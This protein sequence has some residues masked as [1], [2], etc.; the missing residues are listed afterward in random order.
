MNLAQLVHKQGPLPLDQTVRLIDRPVGPGAR[1]RARLVHRDLKPENMLI[2]PDG[3]LRITDFGLAL[4]LR[5]DARFGGATSRSGTPQF[6]SPEQLLGERVDQRADLYSLAATRTSLYWPPAVRGP[7]PEAIIARQTTEDPPS[8]HDSRKDVP[9]E[10][11]DVLGR[12]WRVSPRHVTRRP[13]RSATPCAGREGCCSGCGA[14]LG[15]VSR[16]PSAPAEDCSANAKLTSPHAV[17]MRA[18]RRAPSAGC[19]RSS[20]RG[21]RRSMP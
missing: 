14:A 20:R 17:T 3:R 9:R 18:E 2:E 7:T 13:P 21:G 15:K 11:E 16:G 4:A 6:A 1:T 12:R 8:L 19:R 5:G 10:L